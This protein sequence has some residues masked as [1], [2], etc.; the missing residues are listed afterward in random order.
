MSVVTIPSHMVELYPCFASFRY[1]CSKCLTLPLFKEKKTNF[2]IEEK[3][4]LK[5]VCCSN[6]YAYSLVGCLN[7][8]RTYDYTVMN[9]L[10]S[11]S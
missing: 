5:N 10:V 2:K 9:A 8:A 1:C 3:R 4:E 7:T 6:M 11:C